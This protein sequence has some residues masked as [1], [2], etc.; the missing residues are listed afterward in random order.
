MRVQVEE[1]KNSRMRYRRLREE[2]GV[3]NDQNSVHI[4]KIVK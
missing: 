4:Y 3:E 2:H 1:R